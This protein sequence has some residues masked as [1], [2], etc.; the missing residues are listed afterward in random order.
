MELDRGDQYRTDA[1][2]YLANVHTLVIDWLNEHMKSLITK[3]LA[4]LPPKP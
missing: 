4:P 1:Y 2:R 3:V